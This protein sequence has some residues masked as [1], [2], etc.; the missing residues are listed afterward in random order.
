MGRCVGRCV[1]VW[2]GECVRGY[3]W[4][5]CFPVLFS[6]PMVLSPLNH[7][8]LRTNWVHIYT[9]IRYCWTVVVHGGWADRLL[10]VS[11]GSW[12]R[13]WFGALVGMWFIECFRDCGW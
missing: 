4:L 8:A 2:V 3:G 13:G 10:G 1:R 7:G 9:A 12:V 6:G 5:T 11:M